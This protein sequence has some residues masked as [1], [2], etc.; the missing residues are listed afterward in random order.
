MW[1]LKFM[2]V[3]GL[4]ILV[5]NPQGTTVGAARQLSPGTPTFPLMHSF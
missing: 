5:L 3:S 1:D 2:G 4:G